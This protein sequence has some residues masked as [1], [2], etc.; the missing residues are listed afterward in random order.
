MGLF[1]K[2]LDFIFGE[3]EEIEEDK[4]NQYEKKELLSG[5]EKYFYKILVKHF[6]NDYVVMPQVNLA[7]IIKKRL[8][9]SISKWTIPKYWFWHFW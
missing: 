3:G 7:S 2:I 9:Y 6:G 1:G 5:C 4:P 8:P